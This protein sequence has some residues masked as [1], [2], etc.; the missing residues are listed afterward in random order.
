MT[1][2]VN[3]PLRFQD[4]H[5]RLGGYAK[6]IQTPTHL[7][8]LEG[9]NIYYFLWPDDLTDSLTRS[10]VIEARGIISPINQDTENA[11]DK[12][13]LSQG[14]HFRFNRGQILAIKDLGSSFYQFCEKQNHHFE[15]ILSQG[16]TPQSKNQSGIYIA[17]LL[18]NK[19]HLNSE[20]KE[21]FSKTGSLHL[22]AISGLH[23]GVIAA[24]LAIILHFLRV[25]NPWAPILGLIVLLLYVEITG[26]TPSA[27]RAFMM[28]CFF[29]GAR[30]LTRKKCAFSSLLGSAFLVLLIRPHE[31]WNIGFQ[32]SYCVVGAILLYGLPLNE[33]FHAY[34]K[35]L[36]YP[37]QRWRHRMNRFYFWGFS[38]FSISLAANLASIPLSLYYFETFAPGGIFLNMA[39][40]PIA[41]LVIMGGFLS[42]ILGLM[43]I[44]LLPSLINFIAWK[45]IHLME[46]ILGLFMKIPGL[47]WDAF[48]QKSHGTLITLS[49]L[50]IWLFFVGH[51]YNKLNKVRFYSLPIGL[52]VLFVGFVA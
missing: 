34:L 3:R 32:L 1:F 50:F 9:Q 2:K 42:L 22:F 31:L 30:A 13:L 27:M 36:E 19:A 26:A 16:E 48:S 17:M 11:F 37:G 38:L 20:Q 46:W 4:K 40:I 25:P 28:V 35:T 45:G 23:V 33:K 51:V 39:L 43:G 29:W 52:I 14:I 49:A 8:K 21:A 6:I 5:G 24:C 7:K 10:E 12:F 47:F 41:S 15:S 44:P 18:G